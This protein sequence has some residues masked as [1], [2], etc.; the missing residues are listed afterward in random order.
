MRTKEQQNNI[1]KAFIERRNDYILQVIQKN[2]LLN[3][4]HAYKKEGKKN[5]VCFINRMRKERRIS[6]EDYHIITGKWD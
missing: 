4:Y 3:E 5:L 6:A 1:Y 2:K